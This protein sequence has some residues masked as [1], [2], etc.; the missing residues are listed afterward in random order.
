M[1]TDCCFESN[2]KFKGDRDDETIIASSNRNEDKD[3]ELLFRDNTKRPPISDIK[4]YSK[5]LPASG[6]NK[7]TIDR[8]KIEFRMLRNVLKHTNDKKYP[9]AM[10]YCNKYY[11]KQFCK[12]KSK[13]GSEIACG[14]EGWCHHCSSF[15]LKVTDLKYLDDILA[16]NFKFIQ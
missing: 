6:L 2:R 15:D 13:D 12:R 3:I 16:D 7:M 14:N 5:G 1:Y 4:K 8:L 9:N 10:E 11:M